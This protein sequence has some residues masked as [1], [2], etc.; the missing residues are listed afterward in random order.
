MSHDDRSTAAQCPHLQ[1]NNPMSL[2]MIDTWQAHS[3]AVFEASMA[4]KLGKNDANECQCKA[5]GQLEARVRA[6]GT[7]GANCR[8]ESASRGGASILRCARSREKRQCETVHSYGTYQR[9]RWRGRA[10]GDPTMVPKQV[11]GIA[12]AVR[13][14]ETSSVLSWID[15]STMCSVDVQV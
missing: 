4:L 3:F 10:S 7:P 6:G 9:G 2:C 12:G 5:G 15:V 8:A 14:L 13:G 1:I 11:L